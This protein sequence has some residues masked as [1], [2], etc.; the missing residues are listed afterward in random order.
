MPRSP[1]RVVATERDVKRAVAFGDR[2]EY[3]VRFMRHLVL[4]VS[5]TGGKTWTFHFRLERE[6][7]WR[8]VALGKWP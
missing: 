1:A 3:R 5:P 4:R 2:T 7:K 8:Q 6:K